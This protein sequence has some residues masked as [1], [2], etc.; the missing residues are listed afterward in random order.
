[1][2]YLETKENKGARKMAQHR[3]LFRGLGFGSQCPHDG[4]QPG[5]TGSDAILQTQENDSKIK[6]C[7]H[8]HSAY[9]QL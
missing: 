2:K 1:M 5:G 9:F 4:S 8:N 3:L 6:A 7:F